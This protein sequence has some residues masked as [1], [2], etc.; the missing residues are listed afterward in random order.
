MENYHKDFLNIV[1]NIDKRQKPKLLLHVCCAP[2]S[3]HCLEVVEPFFDVTVF[4]YN[5]NISP[6]TEY[7]KR[8]LEEQKFVKIAHPNVKVVEAEYDSQSF[9]D[10]A[11]GLEDLPEGGERCHKCYELRLKKTAQFARDNNFDFFTTTLTVSPYKNSQVLN[12]IG[13][14]VAKQYG[15]KYLFSDFK[16]QNGY[17]H[18][19]E[20]SHKYNLYRQNY[21][22]CIYSKIAREKFEKA[23]E[24]AQQSK[25]GA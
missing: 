17:L 2:C 10:I 21:C 14:N 8:L 6:K 23:K 18:S 4:F 7:D 19:I 25:L 13:A 22:G 12:E 3:S 11:K 24:Q 16:K 5:P 9:F 1:A 20:L 15:V